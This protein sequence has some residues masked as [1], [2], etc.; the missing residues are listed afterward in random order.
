MLILLLMQAGN[1]F[2]PI[3]STNMRSVKV[4]T[5]TKKLFLDIPENEFNKNKN[6]SDLC[7]HLTIIISK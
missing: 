4:D 6:N 1:L 3:I 7:V 2:R 5:S